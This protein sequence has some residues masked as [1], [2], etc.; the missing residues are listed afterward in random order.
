MTETF[1]LIISFL[2]GWISGMI[3]TA[4]IGQHLIKNEQ[5]NGD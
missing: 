4:Y 1:A 2:L 3:M 5:K